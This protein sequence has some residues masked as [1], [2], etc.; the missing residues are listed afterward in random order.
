MGKKTIVMEAKMLPAFSP[1]K[2]SYRRFCKNASASSLPVSGIVC[3]ACDAI[4]HSAAGAVG[5]V[6][7]IS[8]SATGKLP[9]GC[10]AAEGS[11]EDVPHTAEGCVPVNASEGLRSNG[12][13]RVLLSIC[14]DKVVMTKSRVY[15][16]LRSIMNRKPAFSK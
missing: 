12:T 1:L 14:S 11:W 8:I 4:P 6:G 5:A 7:V 10:E 15:E 16:A 13:A 9:E 2:G 3:E